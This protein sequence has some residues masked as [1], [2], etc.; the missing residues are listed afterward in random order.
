MGLAS[1]VV[2]KYTFGRGTKIIIVWNLTF[3]V[4][5]IKVR[6]RIIL[7]GSL[8]LK[9]KKL[10]CTLFSFCKL[11]LP[12]IVQYSELNLADELSIGHI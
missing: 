9:D 4:L 1:R 12:L 8:S 5:C 11:L 7:D 10:F 6:E 3:V 2:A